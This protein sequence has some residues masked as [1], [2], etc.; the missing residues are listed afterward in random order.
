M[1][2]VSFKL[3]SCNKIFYLSCVCCFVAEAVTDHWTASFPL[4]AW[5]FLPGKGP[6]ASV[7]L[8]LHC[9]SPPNEPS[10]LPGGPLGTTNT[11]LSPKKPSSLVQ[12]TFHNL[13]PMWAC[14]SLISLFSPLILWYFNSEGHV[15]LTRC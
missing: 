15:S 12:N 8:S 10:T 1:M 9:C 7:N 5:G 11:E 6:P 14:F 4:S 13:H 2:G 3:A